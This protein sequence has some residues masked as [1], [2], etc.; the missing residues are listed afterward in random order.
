MLS[1]TGICFHSLCVVDYSSTYFCSSILLCCETK[2]NS[3]DIQA[4]YI[5]R[6]CSNLIKNFSGYVPTFYQFSSSCLNLALHVV[7]SK[8][9][10]CQLLMLIPRSGRAIHPLLLLVDACLYGDRINH[11]TF[12]ALLL[13][14]CDMYTIYL[15]LHVVRWPMKFWGIHLL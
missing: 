4:L 10:P 11:I 3:Y 2:T 15:V 7:N 9:Y 8:K 13:C 12:I 1:C 5:W 14:Y 6:D